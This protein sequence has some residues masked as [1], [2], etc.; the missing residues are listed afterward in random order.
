MQYKAH[1]TGIKMLKS[2]IIM[3]TPICDFVGQY[4]E[5]DT[6]RFHMPGHKGMS[7]LGMEALDITEI[8]GA[9]GLVRLSV[10]GKAKYDTAKIPEFVMKY[11]GS[12]S[13]K[14]GEKPY[15]TYRMARSEQTGDDQLAKMLEFVEDIKKNIVEI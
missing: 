1:L 9:E 5:S 11:K 2:N 10:Y 8:K 4:Q 12:V 15:F 13:L 6:V 14:P 7:H 3:T